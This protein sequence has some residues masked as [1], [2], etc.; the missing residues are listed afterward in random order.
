MRRVVG[1]RLRGAVSPGKGVRTHRILWPPSWRGAP[2][3]RVPANAWAL[4]RAVRGRHGVWS[5]LIAT[6]AWVLTALTLPLGCGPRK[7][8][9][10]PLTLTTWATFL[11]YASGL[12]RIGRGEGVVEGWGKC[13]HSLSDTPCRRRVAET[14]AS[15]REQASHTSLGRTG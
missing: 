4:V 11:P 8:R 1:D 14:L 6:A 3:T 12:R 9:S 13:A 15:L 5:M 2:P 10:Q 7:G